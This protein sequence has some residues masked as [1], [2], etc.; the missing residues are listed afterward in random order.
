MSVLKNKRTHPELYQPRHEAPVSMPLQTE[1]IQDQGASAVGSNETLEIVQSSTNFPAPALSTII[2]QR[3]WE[4][5]RLRKQLE[6]QEKRHVG[7][8][9]LLEDVQGAME[10]LQRALVTFQQLSDEADEDVPLA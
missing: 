3:T 1:V 7:S 4:N 6:R 8:R 10:L 5:D 9:Y 2:E